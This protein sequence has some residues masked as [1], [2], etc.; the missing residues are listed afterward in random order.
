MTTAQLRPLWT[1]GPGGP[2]FVDLV[3]NAERI[4][5]FHISQTM[6]FV[7]K[8]IEEDEAK[9]RELFAPG[10]LE[11][12]RREIAGK[13]EVGRKLLGHLVDAAQQGVG[14]R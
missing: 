14:R 4:S 6:I 11:E 12:L 7:Q 5:N 8:S 1:V 13:L 2:T 9:S 10:K 3:A